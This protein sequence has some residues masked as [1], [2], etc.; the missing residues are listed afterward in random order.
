MMV[1]VVPRDMAWWAILVVGGRLVWM[2][3][4]IFFSLNDSMILSFNGSSEHL[5]GLA[6]PPWIAALHHPEKAS[7]FFTL[8]LVLQLQVLFLGSNFALGT[9]CHHHKWRQEVGDPQLGSLYPPGS[10]PGIW[11]RAGCLMVQ[12]PSCFGISPQCLCSIQVCI[13][14]CTLLPRDGIASP[15]P[16]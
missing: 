9:N 16:G 5:S 2:I 11:E 1:D 6:L 15:N 4:A 12:S 13:L 10:K 8:L 3:S 7:C 14:F